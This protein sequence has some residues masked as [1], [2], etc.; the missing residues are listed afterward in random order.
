MKLSVAAHLPIHV[1]KCR[2]SGTENTE[3]AAREKMLKPEDRRREVG[4]EGVSKDHKKIIQ[5]PNESASTSLWP[6]KQCSG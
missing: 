5:R 1:M 4:D 2:Q 6:R 3:E